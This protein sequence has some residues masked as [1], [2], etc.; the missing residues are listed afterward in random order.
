VYEAEA[1]I[2]D[3]LYGRNKGPQFKVKLQGG[4]INHALWE[5]EYRLREDMDPETLQKMIDKYRAGKSEST[6]QARARLRKQGLTA[7]AMET[8]E[9]GAKRDKP[10]ARQKEPPVLYLLRTLRSYERNHT[11]LELEM[12]AVVWSVLKL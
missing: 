8:V 3:R 2:G 12:G 7:N 1:I 11:I 5:P 6:S 9:E 10:H 4:A